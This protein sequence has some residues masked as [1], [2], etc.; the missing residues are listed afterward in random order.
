MIDAGA[1]RL[2]FR[3]VFARHVRFPLGGGIYILVQAM[4]V[5][6]LLASEIHCRRQGFCTARGRR[7][8]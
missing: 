4:C 6:Q 3:S 7:A 5:Y 2:V 1:V 8:A